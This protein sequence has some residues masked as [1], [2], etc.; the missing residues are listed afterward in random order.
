MATPT[1]EERAAYI[2]QLVA[3]VRNV[4]TEIEMQVQEMTADL[5]PAAPPPMAMMKGRLFAH[6]DALDP[7]PVNP[8]ELWANRP[9]RKE[10]PIVFI[11]RVYAPWIGRGL[12]RAQ[13]RAADRPLY[14][15]L[16]VWLHRHPDETFDEVPPRSHPHAELLAS[17]PPDDIEKLR[18]IGVSLQ[19]RRRSSK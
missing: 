15:A 5:P 9:G 10:N 2:Q 6:E 17:L 18:K 8:S 14:R 19:N 11:R 12:N 16:G 4:L 13:I 7:G 1:R 3:H